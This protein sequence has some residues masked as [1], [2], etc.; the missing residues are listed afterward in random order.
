MTEETLTGCNGVVFRRRS[1]RSSTAP[2]AV[3]TASGFV[4]AVLVGACGVDSSEACN[5]PFMLTSGTSSCR[6]S[7]GVVSA[8][9]AGLCSDIG[10]PAQQQRLDSQIVMTP[11]QGLRKR[12]NPMPRVKPCHTPLRLGPNTLTSRLTR[13][14]ANPG[15]CRGHKRRMAE[16]PHLQQPGRQRRCAPRR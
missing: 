9:T 4:G 1:L 10:S 15:L 16:V 14:C 2:A 11:R 12:G 6:L 8:A 7:G 3:G 5:A 13:P